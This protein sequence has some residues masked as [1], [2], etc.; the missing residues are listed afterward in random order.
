MNWFAQQR[1]AWIAETLEIFGF[2]NRVHLMRKFGI[3][4]AGAALD[5]GTFNE[6]HPDAMHYDNRKKI[7]VSTTAPKGLLEKL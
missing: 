5:L 6:Q 7:Y 2:I 4:R 1:Q 3:S